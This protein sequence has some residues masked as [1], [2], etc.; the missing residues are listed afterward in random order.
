MSHLGQKQKNI[1]ASQNEDCC[2]SLKDCINLLKSSKAARLQ[3]VMLVY[4]LC[5]F[6]WFG[7][8]QLHRATSNEYAEFKPEKKQFT[9]DYAD[10]KSLNQYEMPYIDFDFCW[11]SPGENI[12][13]NI[14]NNYK[15]IVER[16][17]LQTF[18][19]MNVTTTKW[20]K[21]KNGIRGRLEGYPLVVENAWLLRRW[22]RTG[23]FCAN[24]RVKFEDPKPGIGKFEFALSLRWDWLTYNHTL[25]FSQLSVDIH[26][27]RVRD[28][29][30][31]TP[32]WLDSNDLNTWKICQLH[33]E[34]KVLLSSLSGKTEHYFD[35]NLAIWE[36]DVWNNL[37]WGGVL[38]MIF[39]P[40][41]KV[42]HWIDY[43][44][45]GYYD[46]CGMMSGIL[47]FLVVAF[48]WIAYG[49]AIYFKETKS[50]GILPTVSIKFANRKALNLLNA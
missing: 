19:N 30:D 40:D 15:T 6:L 14:R 22:W 17:F 26:R 28:H 38:S 5:L 4:F 29:W 3:S 45:F 32:L 36:S 49:I 10:R 27:D 34:E 2:D 23:L 46:W 39:V 24:I 33:Y 13:H 20:S 37:G 12:T 47:S 16:W 8:T 7:I 43:V 9:I 48:L 41:L 42:D 1:L 31:A 21:W 25:G 18:L 35:T 50:L 11:N 44:D